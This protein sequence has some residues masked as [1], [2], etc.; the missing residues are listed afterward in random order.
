VLYKR[1]GTGWQGSQ[2]RP[3]CTGST[4]FLVSELTNGVVRPVIGSIGDKPGDQRGHRTLYGGIIVQYWAWIPT[5]K[6]RDKA[7]IKVI[8]TIRL[9]QFLNIFIYP[10]IHFVFPLI[11]DSPFYHLYHH[12]YDHL[13]LKWLN[14]LWISIQNYNQQKINMLCFFIILNRF[15]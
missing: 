7:T 5:A 1:K 15:Y 9:L 8:I 12:Y 4:V 14:E 3:G 13:P 6:T 10:S 2:T 11:K